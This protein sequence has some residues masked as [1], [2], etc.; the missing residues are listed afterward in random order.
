MMVKKKKTTEEMIEG[1]AVMVQKGFAETAS[2]DQFREVKSEIKEL[3]EQIERLDFRLTG[4]G[5]RIEILE[6]KVRMLSVK[7]GLK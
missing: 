2:K 4:W 7:V 5:Q 6:D 1:L 3:R